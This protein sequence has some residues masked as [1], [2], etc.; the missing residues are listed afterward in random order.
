MQSRLNGQKQSLIDTEEQPATALAVDRKFNML[1]F[2]CADKLYQYDLF[3]KTKA[4]VLH[5]RQVAS[6]A[7][8]RSYLYLVDRE[9][10]RIE[11]FDKTTNEGRVTVVEH[12]QQITD[13]VAVT[14]LDDDVE[15]GHPCSVRNHFGNCTHLCLRSVENANV[16]ECACPVGMRLGADQKGCAWPQ[17]CGEDQFVCRTTEADCIPQ[18]WRCDGQPDCADESDEERCSCAKDEFQCERGVCVPQTALCDGYADC[19]NGLDEMRHC[20]E[21]HPRVG[22]VTGDDNSN[23]MVMLALGLI[24]FFV[25]VVFAFMHCRVGFKRQPPIA[26][27]DA[28]VM[29]PLAP[30]VCPQITALGMPH[31]KNGSGSSGIG[32]G[33]LCS[34]GSS[35]S[36]ERSHIT[37]A[38][39]SI[40]VNAVPLNPP[41]SPT[42]TILQEEF[43]CDQ[44]SL[45]P[46]PTPCSTFVCDESDVNS[47]VS[48]GYRRAPLLDAG[49]HHQRHHQRSGRHQHHGGRSR[50]TPVSDYYAEERAH[51]YR[52]DRMVDRSDYELPQPPPTP[53]SYSSP[54]PSP[55]SS[56]GL[57]SSPR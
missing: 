26:E 13:L 46:H 29:R 8:M 19:K 48:S 57:S 2:S 24:A 28:V 32:M 44:F 18:Q 12:G 43:C 36:Y 31:M 14:P 55:T 10:Q 21:E 52:A 38:S 16:A 1:Y 53:C 20:A 23:V 40:S 4:V 45:P 7:V 3:E 34:G 50:R 39:S 17:P 25:V 33:A 9:A 6:M 30:D 47:A 42:T 5:D 54:T 22:G 49:Y 56:I 27:Q 35:G 51:A 37:G 15:L 11:R 41:P